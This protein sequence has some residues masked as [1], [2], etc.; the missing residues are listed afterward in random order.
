MSYF[1]MFLVFFLVFF[2]GSCFGLLVA[3]LLEAAHRG[4]E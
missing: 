2:G 4:E 1:W 3:G